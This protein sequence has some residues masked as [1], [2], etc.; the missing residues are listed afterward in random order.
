MCG[1]N[2][3]SYNNECHIRGSACTDGINVT[4]A[5]RGECNGELNVSL[6]ESRDGR[7]SCSKGDKVYPTDKFLFSG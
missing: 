4:V 2:G 5:Y 1:T 6:T 3:K 7:P